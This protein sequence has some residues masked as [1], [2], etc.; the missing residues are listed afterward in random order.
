MTITHNKTLKKEE[1]G[2][3]FLLLPTPNKYKDFAKDGSVDLRLTESY[4]LLATPGF[5]AEYGK[6]CALFDYLSGG[7]CSDITYVKNP[8]TE[9]SGT[10]AGIYALESSVAKR[11]RG[12]L[13][14]DTRTN[15]LDVR[16]LVRDLKRVI[17]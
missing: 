2:G 7:G 14:V 5:F 1:L 6:M 10:M 16:R 3:H 13:I 12:I 17:S 9:K 11:I 8:S 4:E 15:C